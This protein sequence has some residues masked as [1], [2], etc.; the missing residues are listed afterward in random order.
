MGSLVASA[1]NLYWFRAVMVR[2][3]MTWPIRR[4]CGR[5]VW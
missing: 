3:E 4:T 1:L 5:Y 2:S